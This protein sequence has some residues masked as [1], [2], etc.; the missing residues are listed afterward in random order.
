MFMIETLWF[1][2]VYE[3][4]VLFIIFHPQFSMHRSCINLLT[5]ISPSTFKSWHVFFSFQET[6]WKAVLRLGCACRYPDNSANAHIETRASG[7]VCAPLEP[8]FIWSSLCFVGD[9]I[10]DCWYFPVSLQE[11]REKNVSHSTRCELIRWVYSKHVFSLWCGMRIA[12]S[13]T[14]DIT[15]KSSWEVI[16]STW[17]TVNKE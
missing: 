16:K 13:K 14:T 2:K 12:R 3:R 4:T 15:I 1:K 8:E 7:T 9:G 5:G 10:G 17:R 6:V 11:K